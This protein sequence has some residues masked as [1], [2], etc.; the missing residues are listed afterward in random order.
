MSPDGESAE[1]L[2]LFTFFTHPARQ[3]GMFCRGKRIQETKLRFEGS[4]GKGKRSKKVSLGWICSA[5]S[6][7]D[8]GLGR[9]FLED[10]I[11]NNWDAFLR[12]FSSKEYL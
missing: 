1:M 9:A 10:F 12:T 7:R 8:F 5:S 3:R 6:S 2:P 11:R 4:K